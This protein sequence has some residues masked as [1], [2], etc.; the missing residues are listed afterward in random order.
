MFS[1]ALVPLFLEFSRNFSKPTHLRFLLLM[2]AAVL[3]VG[4]RTVS[5]M[6]RT[7]KGMSRG[8]ASSYHRFFSKRA[9]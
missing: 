7:A 5:N 6:L 1:S 8:H 2:G 3:T 9:W 4:R